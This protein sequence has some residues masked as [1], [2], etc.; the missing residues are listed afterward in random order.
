MSYEVDIRAVGDESKSGDAIALRFGE[1]ITDPNSQRVVVI[2]GGFRDSGE[3]LVK[4][5]KGFYE[6]N[7]VDLVIATHPDN[8]HVSGLRVVLEEM[9]VLELW[10]HRPWAHGAQVRSLVESAFTAG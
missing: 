7:T 6:T 10:M 4:H 3:D 8:D 1:F 5:I 2:D 9:E